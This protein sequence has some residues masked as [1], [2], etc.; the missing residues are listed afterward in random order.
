MNNTQVCPLT[1]L[2]TAYWEDVRKG[3]EN[4][5]FRGL[6]TCIEWKA[7]EFSDHV[8]IKKKQAVVLTGGGVVDR[9]R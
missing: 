9:W 2:K 7:T 4:V 6:V 1:Y 5:T 8:S 3:G